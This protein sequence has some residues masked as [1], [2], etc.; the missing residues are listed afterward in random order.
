MFMC[1][2]CSSSSSVTS[3]TLQH[4][5]KDFWMPIFWIVMMRIVRNMSVKNVLK[6]K[7]KSFSLSSK[8]KH[9][10]DGVAV[11]SALLLVAFWLFCKSK[12]EC[13]WKHNSF[14]IEAR[15]SNYLLPSSFFIKFDW[16]FQIVRWFFKL[17]NDC[18][19]STAL[20]VRVVRLCSKHSTDISYYA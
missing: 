4:M 6:G 8:L 15:H 12:L 1:P 17:L 19:H 18:K 11:V 3:V 2:K 10:R 7:I 20:C 9:T 14:R 13:K 16:C 5:L